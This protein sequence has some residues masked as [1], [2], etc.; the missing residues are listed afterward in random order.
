MGRQSAEHAKD[1]PRG[2]GSSDDVRVL[3]LV[4]LRHKGKAIHEK[5]TQISLCHQTV[6]IC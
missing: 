4:E 5:N 2:G 1:L 6:T 3:N